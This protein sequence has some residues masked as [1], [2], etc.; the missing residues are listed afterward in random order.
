MRRCAV[1]A[2]AG[3]VEPLSLI[4]KS[5]DVRTEDAGVLLAEGIVGDVTRDW[6]AGESVRR[7]A[8]VVIMKSGRASLSCLSSAVA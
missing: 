8:I 4:G 1:A 7:D 3:V 6:L 5:M 2:L